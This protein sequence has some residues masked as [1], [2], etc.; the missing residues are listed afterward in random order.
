[1]KTLLLLITSTLITAAYIGCAARGS[2][3][4]K[5]FSESVDCKRIAQMDVDMNGVFDMRDVDIVKDPY[6]NALV[7]PCMS[8][9]D[10]NM[11]GKFDATDIGIIERSLL[12]PIRLAH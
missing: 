3:G 5:T 4:T 11:D 1:M 2:Y 10:M 8:V 9:I 12:T 6:F 7:Y